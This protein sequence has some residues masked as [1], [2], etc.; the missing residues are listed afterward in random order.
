MTDDARYLQSAAAH[1]SLVFNESGETARGVDWN[2]DAS[3][4][5]RF[6]QLCRFI[7]AAV[8]FSINDIGC[9]YGALV[10]FLARAGGEFSYH[11]FDVSSPMIESARLRYGGRPD[12][13]F[14]CSAQLEQLADYSGASGIFHKRFGRSDGEMLDYQL[15]TLDMMD[16]ASRLGFSFNSF[17]R[18]GAGQAQ[19]SDL[20]YADPCLLF[21]RCRTR[22]AGR[23]ALLHDY[24]PMDFTIA[25]RKDPPPGAGTGTS[26]PPASPDLPS[27]RD[28]AA[29]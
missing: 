23:V 25:V 8:P 15:R 28:A 22:F 27:H 18:Y 3:Q 19:R 5:T 24:D 11:G 6:E 21:D 7:D 10:D 26:S 4:L 1:F 2:S 12:I 17:S 13:R 9:G 20:F 16:R 29:P 14:S